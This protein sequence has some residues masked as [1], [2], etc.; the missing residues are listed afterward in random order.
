VGGR[1]VFLVSEVAILST[2]IPQSSRAGCRLRSKK[3]AVAFHGS[4]VFRS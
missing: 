2:G 4:C 1:L 3:V